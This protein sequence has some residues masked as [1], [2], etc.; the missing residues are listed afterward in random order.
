MEGW[1]LEAAR[2]P[3]F[4]TLTRKHA[5]NCLSSVIARAWTNAEPSGGKSDE[6]L[7]VCHREERSDVAIHLTSSVD[8]RSRQASFAMTNL[9]SLEGAQPFRQAQGPEPCRGATKQSIQPV[10]QAQGPS[11]SRGWIAAPSFLGLA[12]TMEG[13]K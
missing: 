2:S 4:F 10:R 5:A 13:V 11:L 6:P 12:M 9:S 8:C 1:E 3:A 7:L